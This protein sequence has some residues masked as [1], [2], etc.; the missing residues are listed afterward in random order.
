[1][2][3]QRHDGRARISQLLA[4]H[5]PSVLGGV[6]G[7]RCAPVLTADRV[8]TVVISSGGQQRGAKGNKRREVLLLL[9][10]CDRINAYLAKRANAGI[11][12]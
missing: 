10:A 11:R 6:K 9:D 2:V 12:V 5:S 8:A 4:V 3:T 7:L 1:M